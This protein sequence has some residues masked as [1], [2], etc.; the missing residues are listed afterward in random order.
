MLPWWKLS[1]CVLFLAG[2]A[3]KAPLPEVSESHPAHPAARTTPP[4]EP[5]GVLKVDEPVDEP[6]P[7]PMMHHGT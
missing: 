2:C 6:E 4:P 3:W 1:V 5:S 7:M